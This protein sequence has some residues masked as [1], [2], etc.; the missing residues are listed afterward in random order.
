[1]PNQIRPILKRNCIFRFQFNVEPSM[2]QDEPYE[3]ATNN[4]GTSTTTI[5]IV[6][7]IVVLLLIVAIAVGMYY[8][9]KNKMCCFAPPSNKEAR[10]AE[11]QDT[12]A[13]LNYDDEGD[14]N[15]RPILKPEWAR[16]QQ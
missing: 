11:E 16:P 3:P 8:I 13:P 10:A 14:K 4:L 15:S 12:N 9:R 5:I 7:V 6:V 2:E 1:M